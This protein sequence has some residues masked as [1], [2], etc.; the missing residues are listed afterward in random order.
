VPF[1]VT[2]LPDKTFSSGPALAL[3]NGTASTLM[4][5]LSGRLETPR[6]LVTTRLSTRSTPLAVNG[7]VNVGDTAVVLLSVT[8]GPDV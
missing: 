7:A 1:R 6:E 8:A 3:G 2:K 5:T 4:V